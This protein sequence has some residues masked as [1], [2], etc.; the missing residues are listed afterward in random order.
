MRGMLSNSPTPA[1]PCSP[2]QVAALARLQS[3]TLHMCTYT[4]ASCELVLP[5]L[6]TSLRRLRMLSRPPPVCISRLSGLES[7]AIFGLGGRVGEEAEQYL[8]AAVVPLTQLT[9][10]LLWGVRTP[11]LSALQ[12]LRQLQQLQLYY[13]ELD[14][15]VQQLPD[16]PWLG[17]L[18]SLAAEAPVLACSLPS[19]AAATQ[20]EE[21]E[22]Y[23]FADADSGT[24][25]ALL[26]WAGST[27]APLRR[28]IVDGLP[29]S[30]RD[31]AAAAMQAK[32]GLRI[33]TGGSPFVRPWDP[34]EEP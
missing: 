28:L 7:L 9:S 3:L 33:C 31:A 11:S 23:S 30:S 12:G 17:G 32:P 16:G 22:V 5:R 21:L 2:L 8:L 14:S 25:C 20:L 24:R 27:A 26:Q 10:L 29:A 4:E 34:A 19:L 13:S 15:D 18:S 1:C 6:S